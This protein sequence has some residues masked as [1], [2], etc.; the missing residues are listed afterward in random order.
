MTAGLA[1]LTLEITPRSRYDAIDVATVV[2]ERF[3]DVLAGHRRA[4]Y[5]SYHTTAGFLE[6]GLAARLQDR[7]HPFVGAFRALFPPE[8]GYRHDCLEERAEL[9]AEQRLVEPKNADSHLAFIASGLRNC[10][11]YANRPGEPVFFLDLDGVSDGRHRCRQASVLAYDEEVLVERRACEVEVSRHPID[12][13]NLA[14]PRHGV[15]PLAEEMLAR[16]GAG[17]GR[18]RIALDADE[19]DAGVTVNEF[20]TLLMRHDLAEVLRDPLRFIARQGRRMLADPAAIATKS[21]GYAKYDAVRLLNELLDA[22]GMSESTVERILARL[23]A[24]PA[25]RRL[26]FKRS[27]S[28]PVSDRSGDGRARIVRGTYQSP[29]LIQWSR[30]PRGSRRL[31]VELTRFR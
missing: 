11:A 6:Q 18:V 30:P 2:R 16:A 28:L 25:A 12:S 27:A 19:R 8:A 31:V 13:L 21:W 20:E 1:E 15:L 4:L 24:V 17:K 22:L 26:R 7:L 14:D 5:C 29:I 3:G 10:A 9:S 23:M